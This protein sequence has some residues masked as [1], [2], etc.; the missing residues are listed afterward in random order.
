MT[1][2]EILRDALD[3][4]LA[5]LAHWLPYDLQHDEYNRA[6]RLRYHIARRIEMS[7]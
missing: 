6:A 1:N 7:A 2:L 4:Y 5:A 3:A